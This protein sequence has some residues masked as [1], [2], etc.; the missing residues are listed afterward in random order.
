MIKIDKQGSHDVNDINDYPKH[1]RQMNKQADEYL[2]MCAV[3]YELEED[4]LDFA[5]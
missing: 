1:L 3:D 2:N 5:D 4:L